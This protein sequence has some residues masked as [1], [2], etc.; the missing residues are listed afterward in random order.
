M[1]DQ[2]RANP[3]AM[4]GLLVRQLAS[5]S[6]TLVRAS[7]RRDAEVQ[8]RT[9]SRSSAAS[10]VQAPAAPSPA[11]PSPTSNTEGNVS[12]NSVVFTGRQKL[13]KAQGF[14]Q[15]D[16]DQPQA[17][18]ITGWIRSISATVYGYT[19]VFIDGTTPRPPLHGDFRT[20]EDD[21]DL[22][23]MRAQFAKTNL[24][25]EAHETDT[26]HRLAQLDRTNPAVGAG[27]DLD[28]K[29]LLAELA[30]LN[31]PRAART[32]INNNDVAAM[33]ADLNQT[34]IAVVQDVTYEKT[35]DADLKQMRAE[36]GV[37]TSSAKDEETICS[38]RDI[39]PVAILAELEGGTYLFDNDDPKNMLADLQQRSPSGGQEPLDDSDDDMELLRGRL[40]DMLSP[41][42]DQNSPADTKKMSSLSF[43]NSKP[44]TVVDPIVVPYIIALQLERAGIPWEE[45]QGWTTYLFSEGLDGHKARRAKD[46]IVAQAAWDLDQLIE[47]VLLEEKQYLAIDNEVRRPCRLIVSNIAAGACVEDLK[48]LFSSQFHFSM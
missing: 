21:G 1:N 28:S 36:F 25:T 5:I 37:G 12:C 4:T 14:S 23:K 30:Q 41:S 32:E 6:E 9:A 43:I 10:A 45:A 20:D 16:L 22:K 48:D 26:K 31:S 7:R 17:D 19:N 2:A 47:Y 18:R 27:E 38:S 8:R 29:K 42:Y 34:S 33:F 11:N 35:E 3:A 24:S 39:D 40:T 15:F 44:K 13:S 46:E